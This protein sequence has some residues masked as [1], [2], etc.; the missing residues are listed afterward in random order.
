MNVIDDLRF[1]A[2][3]PPSKVAGVQQATVPPNQCFQTSK[4]LSS[5]NPLEV[6]DIIE[7]EDC[8]FLKFVKSSS[9]YRY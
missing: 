9:F 7:T 1:R 3:Q 4:G 8:L 5:T 6:R 2:P